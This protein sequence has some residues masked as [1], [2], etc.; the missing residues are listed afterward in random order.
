VLA[1]VYGLVY[2]PQDRLAEWFARRRLRDRTPAE[3]I[4]WHDLSSVH[5]LANFGLSTQLAALG[6]C[7]LLGRPALYVY[8][9]FACAAV[10]GALLGRRELLARRA[11]RT[12]EPLVV[13][14]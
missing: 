2:G 9:T 14:D 6:A 1:R 7:L 10:L 12:L 5:V 3:R 4:A 8:L 11:T 13:V